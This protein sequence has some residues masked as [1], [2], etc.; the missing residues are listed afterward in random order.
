MKRI[1]VAGGAGFLGSHLCE[2]LIRAGH[3][4][5]CIDNLQTGSFANVERLTGSNRFSFVQQSI[6]ESV[7]VPGPVDEIY[8]LAC[9]ASPRHYQRDPLDTVMINVV[10]V[11]NLLAL[12]REKSARLLQSSTSEVYGDPLTPCQSEADW[13]NVNC[14]GPRACYDEGKRCA[15]TIL[16]DAWR[17]SRTPV[18]V[19][20]IFNTYGPG[21][22]E[23]DG[24][25]ISSFMTQAIRG[26]PI[27]V[28]GDGSQTRSFCYVEDMI[29][30]LM[31]L[32]KSEEGFVG[33]V[34]L[35]NPEELTCLAL[36]RRIVRLAASQSQIV[37]KPLP[38]DD[39]RRRRP[40]ILLARQ[41]LGWAPRV[42]LDV[43]LRR[44][45]A[46]YRGRAVAGAPAYS[47]KDAA[48]RPA[49]VAAATP[50]PAAI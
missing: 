7:A 20:R 38:T 2:R 32:M 3:H 15:E 28:Y 35:G 27:T 19:A 42:R 31:R 8:N 49:G 5:T 48:Q 16:F 36:A 9:P 46:Y 6:V 37:F 14:T 39:P 17:T 4:V 23:N 50:K 12:A 43:G 41:A 21:M 34:N 45:L 44:T 26:E 47:L 13:G 11:S 33:P 22:D 10:G 18:K 24:R 29:D 30:G 25:V 1:V 40:D